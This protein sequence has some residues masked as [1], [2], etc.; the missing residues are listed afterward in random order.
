MAKL[1]FRLAIEDAIFQPYEGR[2]VLHKHPHYSDGWSSS[3]RNASQ[4][5]LTVKSYLALAHWLTVNSEKQSS[6]QENQHKLLGILGL[7]QQL[8]HFGSLSL[9]PLFI[10]FCRIYFIFCRMSFKK[11]IS[12]VS[13][14]AYSIVDISVLRHYGLIFL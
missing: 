6:F 7:L 9:V 1:K 5:D 12:V 13:A 8:L 14:G 2:L 11:W 10:D 3:S 4:V